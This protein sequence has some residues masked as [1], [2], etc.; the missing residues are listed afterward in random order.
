[1]L[2]GAVEELQGRDDYIFVHY[3]SARELKMSSWW[4]GAGLMVFLRGKNGILVSLNWR[5]HIQGMKS[6]KLSELVVEH[7][8]G[9]RS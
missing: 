6:W 3:P 9:R 5:L 4:L 7:P 8:W 1:M 2:N